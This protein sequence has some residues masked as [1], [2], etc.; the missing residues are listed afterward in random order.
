MPRPSRRAFLKAAGGFL[1]ASAL[2]S[3]SLAG[4]F[5]RVFGR[6]EA[7]VTKPITP[8]EEFY[9][10]SYR[11]PPTIRLNE[12][13]LSITGLV[14]RPRTLDYS[15]LLAKPTVSQIVTL[16]CVGNMVAG[17][18]MSTAA[19][20]GPSLRL[21]LE[22]SGAQADAYDV[23]FRAADGYSDSIRLDRAMAGD[24]MLAHRMNGVPLPPG[25]G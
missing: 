9:L 6:A 19:W 22:E 17:E 18:F 3:P 25:H 4:L 21:L 10:T 2:P 8:N 1:L 12:W 13:S 16:E 7:K 15:Q 24:V 20:E 5:D 14:E 11:S 23:V